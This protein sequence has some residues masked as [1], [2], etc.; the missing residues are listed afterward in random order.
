MTFEVLRSALA[1]R[2]SGV[3]IGVSY[4]TAKLR[5]RLHIACNGIHEVHQPSMNL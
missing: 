5:S 3:V 1:E 4:G 2:L